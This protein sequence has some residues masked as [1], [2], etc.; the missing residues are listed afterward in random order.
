MSFELTRA[1]NSADPS[2]STLGPGWTHSLAARLIVQANGDV[3]A[4][5]GD[6]QEILFTRNGDSTFS[7]PGRVGVQS[8]AMR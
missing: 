6:G 3:L 7:A 2:S 5:S 1:Y 8:S 4:K